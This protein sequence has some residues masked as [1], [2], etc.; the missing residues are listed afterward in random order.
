[1]LQGRRWRSR[2]E[3]SSPASRRADAAALLPLQAETLNAGIDEVGGANWKGA[4][5]AEARAAGAECRTA[6]GALVHPPAL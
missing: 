3:P 6:S 2:A 5:G 1:M 4:L